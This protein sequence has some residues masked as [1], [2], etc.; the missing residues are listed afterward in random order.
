MAS[1]YITNEIKTKLDRKILAWI[2]YNK[3]FGPDVATKVIGS[4]F[5]GWVLSVK[6]R[7]TVE[8]ITGE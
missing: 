5:D 3:L 7:P 4:S 8:F 1:N 2:I 6:E